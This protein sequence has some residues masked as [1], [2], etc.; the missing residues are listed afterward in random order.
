MSL[1][2]LALRLAA[3]EALSPFAAT[4]TGGPYPT[5]AGN[6]IFDSRIDPIESPDEWEAFLTQIEGNPLVILYTD[7]QE[8]TPKPGANYPAED[9]R[10]DL[11][12]E[13]MI[14]ARGMVTVQGPEGAETIGA[15]VTQQIGTIVAPLSDRFRE[16]ILDI[17]EAQIRN[18]FDLISIANTSS[19]LFR[20]IAW[21]SHHI[22]SVPMREQ[23]GMA[24]VAARTCRFSLKGR[25]DEWAQPAYPAVSTATGLNVLPQPLLTVANALDPSSSG[26]LLCAQLAQL[27]ST[28]ANLPHLTPVAL[29]AQWTRTHPPTFS[30]PTDSA[31]ASETAPEDM[32]GAANL[33]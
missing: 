28:P 26:G 23:T 7:E 1:A 5:I 11:V 30:P 17:L 12:A 16:G 9:E 32:L 8:T 15:P 4:S 27:I 6:N 31:V 13:I 21:E 14:A 20:Q 29:Y 10:I 22:H 33:S 18:A 24:R 3:C 2:R 19:S 25:R